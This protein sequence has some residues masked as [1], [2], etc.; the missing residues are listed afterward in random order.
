[1][2]RI[3][4]VRINEAILSCGNALKAKLGLRREDQ[5][6]EDEDFEGEEREGDDAEFYNYGGDGSSSQYDVNRDA[7]IMGYQGPDYDTNVPL[8]AAGATT[9]ETFIRRPRRRHGTQLFIYCYIYIILHTTVCCS[10]LNTLLNSLFYFFFCRA[11]AAAAFAFLFS[12]SFIACKANA[13]T[14]CC[15]VRRCF[16]YF[17]YF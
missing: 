12:M 17:F 8:E 6:Y 10:A 2:F 3:W 7:E 13:E 14:F 5:Y 1:M 4:E 15:G 9:T 16:C 11:A